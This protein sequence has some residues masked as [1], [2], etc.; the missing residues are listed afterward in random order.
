MSPFPHRISFFL[1]GLALL[2]A[3]AS[4]PSHYY[5]LNPTQQASAGPV[6]STSVAVGPVSVPE[7]VNRPEIMVRIGPNQL[8][9]DEFNR[10]AAP[11]EGDIQRVVIE[12]LSQLLGTPRVFRYPQGPITSPDFRVEIEVLRFESAPGDAALLDVFWTVRGKSEK[13][14][15]TGRTTSRE[16]VTDKSYDALAAA[17]SRALGQLSSDLSEAILEI[18]RLRE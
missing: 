11:L 12:N 15:R 13:D 5:T 14:L 8:A 2:T 1:I 18:E 4:P 16:S 7:A 6:S 10:W 9:L 17:H 3:C